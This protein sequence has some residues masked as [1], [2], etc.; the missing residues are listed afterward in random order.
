LTIANPAIDAPTIAGEPPGRWMLARALAVLL[1]VDGLARLVL[2]IFAIGAAAPFIHWPLG[3]FDVSYLAVT[4]GVLAYA[5]LAAVPLVLA[6]AMLRRPPW[7]GA[8]APVLCLAALLFE[9]HLAIFGQFG[10]R[11]LGLHLFGTRELYLQLGTAVILLSAAAFAAWA[12]RTG[13]PT[14]STFRPSRYTRSAG[15]LLAFLGIVQLVLPDFTLAPAAAYAWDAAWV[16]WRFAFTTSDIVA[17]RFR[18]VVDVLTY[19]ATGAAAL[20]A[21]VGLVRRASWAI[22]VG[23][24]VCTFGLALN[25][26]GFGCFGCG[27]SSG[28]LGTSYA[29]WMAVILI[30]LVASRQK[31]RRQAAAAGAVPAAAAPAA[32]TAISSTIPDGDGWRVALLASLQAT[33]V[34]R[35]RRHWARYALGMVILVGIGASTTLF[36]RHGLPGLLRGEPARVQYAILGLW[37]AGGMF[38][39][40]P[41][42]AAGR[43]ALIA[44]RAKSA[45]DELASA[46]ARRP[47]LYL[48]SFE[49]DEDTSRPSILE[50][51]GI[52]L[53][54]STPEQKLAQQLS[55]V[56]PVIAIGRPG[57]A[58]PPLG[59]ARFYV[60][61]EL[62]KQKVADAAAASRLVVWTSGVSEGLRWEISY[63]LRSLSMERLVLWAHPHLVVKRRG[64]EPEWSRFLKAL[65]AMFPKPFPATLGTTELF[66]FAQDGAPVPV[67]PKL[68]LVHRLLRPL[69]G[70]LVPALKAMLAMKGLAA[71][72]AA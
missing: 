31:P 44:M 3:R 71:S 57:E 28:M 52:L 30:M 13:A 63:L 37:Y 46:G 26:Q 7:L 20:I 1:A 18:I 62:W 69:L 68:G 38:V 36:A 70:A 15:L 54:T 2:L 12:A 8:A 5:L 58:L 64:R 65:G 32:E 51:F 14:A 29:L 6:W 41:F 21:G 55:R 67:K 61:D 4:R 47:I 42:L 40:T 53:A 43:R 33:G 66:V 27:N 23:I 45:S 39:V 22:P 19:G 16:L 48:R 34:E 35:P 60:T 10:R 17:E 9:L 56:G 25:L 24:V 49:I 59:A 50:F 11:A 72:R